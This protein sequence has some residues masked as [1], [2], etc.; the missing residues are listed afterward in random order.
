V[1]KTSKKILYR[2]LEWIGPWLI[3]IIG[4][5]LR[6][7]RVNSQAADEL[8]QRSQSYLLCVWHG[9]L[10]LPVFHHRHQGI[11]AMV[12]RHADGELIS[13]IVKKFGYGTVRGSS[14]RGGKEAFYQLLT[15][16]KNGAAGAMIPDGPT[17][18]RHVLKVGTILLA[19]QADCPLVPITFAA[20]PCWRLKSWDRMVLPKPFARAVIYYGD[21][22]QI[23]AELSSVELEAQ[24]QKVEQ[25]M[26]DLV[27]AAEAHLGF[28]FDRNESGQN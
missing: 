11:I 13:R 23:P 7:E 26:L 28:S 1:P 12:S 21:P 17:G 2:L 27:Q 5:S 19:Q 14:T 16:L 20:R 3:R 4:Y 18:P 15:H 9:R 22:I 10:F 25:A 24:R 6:V 8:H